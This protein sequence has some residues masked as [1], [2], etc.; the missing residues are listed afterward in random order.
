MWTGREIVS[1]VLGVL[2]C[3]GCLLGFAFLY[4][5]TQINW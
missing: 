3:V 1:A 4:Y 2:V 5:A